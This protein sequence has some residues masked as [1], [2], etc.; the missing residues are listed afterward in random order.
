[1][2]VILHEVCETLFSGLA[3]ITVLGRWAISVLRCL[4]SA[5]LP[6]SCVFLPQWAS[7]TSV[8]KLKIKRRPSPELSL[9]MWEQFITP[10][11]LPRLAAYWQKQIIFAWRTVGI[12][13]QVSARP[14]ALAHLSALVTHLLL[15]VLWCSLYLQHPWSRSS[16]RWTGCQYHSWLFPSFSH[17]NLSQSSTRICVILCLRREPFCWMASAGSFHLIPLEP[18]LIWGWWNSSVWFLRGLCVFLNEGWGSTG[19]HLWSWTF[20]GLLWEGEQNR[21]LHLKYRTP[22]KKWDLFAMLITVLF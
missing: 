18:I 3:H 8:L 10:D 9:A 15:D 14:L 7:Y 11:A 12:K 6:C 19:K 16:C 2:A 21:K 20:L 1:M 22:E 17:L 5:A 13:V 4:C